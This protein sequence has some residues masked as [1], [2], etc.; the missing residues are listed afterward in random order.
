EDRR[1]DV[2]VAILKKKGSRHHSDDGVRHWSKSEMFADDMGIAVEATTP[3]TITDQ[4]HTGPAE[5]CFVR[6]KIAAESRR[7]PQ[8]FQK[9]RGHEGLFQSL[10]EFTG[11]FRGV[12]RV[13]PRNRLERGIPA[14]PIAQTSGRYERIR[15][16]R[17]ALVQ[18][19]ELIGPGKRQRLQE[20]R[21]NSGKD[22]A[23]GTDAESK[24]EHNSDR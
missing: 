6:S 7:N 12:L 24:C 14:I 20:N 10:G 3:I 11:N 1:P 19:H 22:R 8:D 17:T 2:N 16:F 18:S 9:A 23:V 4:C 15:A 13:I 5:S 21:I